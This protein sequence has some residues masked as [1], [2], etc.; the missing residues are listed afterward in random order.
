LVLVEQKKQ[1]KCC[2]PLSLSHLQ[3]QPYTHTHTHTHTHIHTHTHKPS[4]NKQFKLT[5]GGRGFDS[6]CRES[7][8]SYNYLINYLLLSCF[9]NFNCLFVIVQ[10][11]TLEINSFY[12]ERPRTLE[13]RHT[14]ILFIHYYCIAIAYRLIHTSS[15][16]F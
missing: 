1:A 6:H 8:F 16:L 12:F 7:Y 4:F 3:K 2:T 13:Y 5:S 15:T 9:R 10:H 11:W 14:S